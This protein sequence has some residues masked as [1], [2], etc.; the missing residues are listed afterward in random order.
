MERIAPTQVHALVRRR[1][2]A[3]VAFD[4]HQRLRA[5]ADEEARR[6]VGAEH[7][8]QERASTDCKDEDEEDDD[9][10]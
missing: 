10:D 5:L 6:Q 8:D 2:A 4:A 9:D 1:V 3:A 7:E